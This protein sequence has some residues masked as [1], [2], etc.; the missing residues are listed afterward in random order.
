[1]AKQGSP[2]RNRTV[3]SGFPAERK[4][5]GIGRFRVKTNGTESSNPLRSAKQ[6]SIFRILERDSPATILGDVNSLYIVGLRPEAPEVVGTAQLKRIRWAA[7]RAHDA[8][9]AS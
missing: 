4:S 2:R 5:A 1:V 8:A 3:S 7:L 6:S 9:I